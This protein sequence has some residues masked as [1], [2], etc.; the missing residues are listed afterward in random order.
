M[1]GSGGENPVGEKFQT[2]SPVIPASLS[3]T[4]DFSSDEAREIEIT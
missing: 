1:Q 3:S 4:P 2:K